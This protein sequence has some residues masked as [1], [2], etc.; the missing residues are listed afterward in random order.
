MT[1]ANLN[2]MVVNA[3]VNQADVIRLQIGRDVEIQAESVPGAGMQGVV[4]RIAPQALIKNGI[5]GFAARIRIKRT[6][7]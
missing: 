5:K 7:S 4:E 1:I 6:T 2:E 3:H